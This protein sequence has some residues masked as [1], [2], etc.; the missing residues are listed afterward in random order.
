[1]RTVRRRAARVLA[2]ALVLAGCSAP[3]PR[4][5][6]IQWIVS[7]PVPAFA[8]GASGVPVRDALERLLTRGLVDEDASGRIVPSAAAR[9][10]WSDDR[11]TLTFHL[12]RPLAFV[13]GT[14]CTSHDFVR[15]LTA[16]LA[17]PAGVTHAWLLR[18][19]AGVDPARVARGHAVTPAIAA[20][21]ESTLVITLAQPDSLLLTALAL[22]GLAP[23]WSASSRGWQGAV[24]TGPYRVATFAP[25]RWL[26][27][28][29]VPGDQPDSIEVRFV[30]APGRVV[31]LLRDG[32]QLVWP[33][34]PVLATAPLPEHTRRATARPSPPRRLVLVLHRERLPTA[35][36]EVREQLVRAIHR[37]AVLAALGARG[38]P[39][40]EWFPGGGRYEPPIEG[41]S[42]EAVPM[43]PFHAEIRYDPAGEVGSVVRLLQADWSRS[44]LDIELEPVTGDPPTG[45]WPGPGATMA[46]VC[47][48]PPLNTAACELAGVVA[49]PRGPALDGLDTGWRVPDWNV[50]QPLR[51]R[52]RRDSTLADDPGRLQQRVDQERVVNPLAEL[53]WWWIERDGMTVPV[54][55]R[56]GPECARITSVGAVSRRRLGH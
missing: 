5:T 51:A 1:M 26:L 9:W 7:A 42:P 41:E 40:E 2:V 19:V 12:R 43:R 37:A 21:D 17:G 11:R 14:P 4:G 35:R 32:A 29:A 13:D 54:H 25:E 56:Y 22:P 28:R 8:P 55:P 45:G 49:P 16:A 52:V 30:R 38:G 53:Q 39:V 18:S 48:S 3:R 10:A 20:P 34:P 15:A 31:G 27:L 44:G 24:G 47:W 50:W 6:R 23:A 33:V 36:R 46:L